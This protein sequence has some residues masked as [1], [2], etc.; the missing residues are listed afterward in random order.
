MIVLGGLLF[1]FLPVLQ[2]NSEEF[3]PVFANNSRE[4]KAFLEHMTEV[5]SDSPQGVYDTLLELRLQNWA[6]EQDKQV[7][8]SPALY[9]ERELWCLGILFAFLPAHNLSRWA[10][11]T[12]DSSY[13]ILD[14]W[15]IN[16]KATRQL[17]E[18]SFQW[19][20]VCFVWVSVK[21]RF[22]TIQFLW[23]DASPT[24]PAICACSHLWGCLLF[25]WKKWS[26]LLKRGIGQ[27]EE[28]GSSLESCNCLSDFNAKYLSACCFP[29]TSRFCFL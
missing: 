20:W 9:F 4:L 3:I 14:K 16:E 28:L 5:Q 17:R 29:S 24:K 2:A 19:G 27:T 26:S 22:Q 11:L 15:Q 12:W 7:W 25:G 10:V 21:Y 18:Y 23:A 1:P 8:V 6:H 13:A